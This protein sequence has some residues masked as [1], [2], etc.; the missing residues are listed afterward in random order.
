MQASTFNQD[1]GSW[2]VS[3]ATTFV[4]FDQGIQ[5]DIQFSVVWL[6]FQVGF[7]VKLLTDMW[8]L[9]KQVHSINLVFHLFLVLEGDVLAG[10]Y[11][12]SRPQ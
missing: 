3:S 5:F 8:L 9:K 12:Q 10:L 11:F 2:D 7:R 6:C 4:S 1:L